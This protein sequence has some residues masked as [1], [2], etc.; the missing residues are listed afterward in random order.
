[1]K[2]SRL[3]PVSKKR[4]AENV[5]RKVLM[6]EKFGPRDGWRCSL[7]EFIGQE[8]FGRYCGDAKHHGAVNGHELLKRSRGGSIVDMKNVILC[9][10]H[11]GWVEDHPGYAIALGLA[12]HSWDDAHV[13]PLTSREADSDDF[14]E[15]L[16]TEE[17]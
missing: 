11:N 17:Q 2:R 6:E 3:R 16:R 15:F 4:E 13:S 10:C 7:F 8:A 9:D 14:Q 12:R 1:M 5:E